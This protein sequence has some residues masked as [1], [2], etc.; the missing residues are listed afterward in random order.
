ML[1][2][3]LE[4]ALDELPEEQRDIFVAHEI[5]GYS[6]KELSAMTGLSV[7]TLLSRKHYAWCFNFR[8]AACGYSRRIYMEAMRIKEMGPQ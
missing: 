6:F 5:E 7:N 2:D 8:R 4:L 1:L 3:E